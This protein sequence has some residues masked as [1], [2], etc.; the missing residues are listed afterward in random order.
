MTARRPLALLLATLATAGCDA[1]LEDPDDRGDGPYVCGDTASLSI[2]APPLPFPRDGS[3]LGARP[4]AYDVRFWQDTDDSGRTCTHGIYRSTGAWLDVV[5]DPA[6]DGEVAADAIVRFDVPDDGHTMIQLWTAVDHAA[7]TPVQCPGLPFAGDYSHVAVD[8]AGQ[9]ILRYDALGDTTPA[10][11]ST[12]STCRG[13]GP[14]LAVDGVVP[15][16]TVLVGLK[17]SAARPL[18]TVTVTAS[19][20][21][22]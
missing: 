20:V 13:T 22:P 1:A 6:G 18:E 14:W 7:G 3:G 11:T 21:A 9:R 2:T 15:P 5:D 8:L 17:S 4:L 19:L 10:A 16:A 12:L